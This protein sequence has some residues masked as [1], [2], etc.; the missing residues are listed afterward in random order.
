MNEDFYST[1]K[2][3][4]ES[5]WDLTEQH[6]VVGMLVENGLT[7]SNPPQN[8]APPEADSR[9][10]QS[11]FNLQSRGLTCDLV[12]V[13]SQDRT[14]YLGTCLSLL[15]AFKVNHPNLAAG[16]LTTGLSEKAL[17]HLVLNEDW[18]LLSGPFFRG[19]LLRHMPQVHQLTLEL[20]ERLAHH[21]TLG[22]VFHRNRTERYQRLSNDLDKIGAYKHWLSAINCKCVVTTNEQLDPAAHLICAAKELGI[23]TIRF[24]M[25]SRRVCTRP[26]Y[27]TSFGFGM[28]HNHK[29]FKT[30]GYV[31]NNYKFLVFWSLSIRFNKN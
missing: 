17:R 2:A 3:L 29:P 21:P 11:A 13:P 25:G 16:I 30:G 7:S 15:K 5:L 23:E 8:E 4:T 22:H 1:W 19:P 9:G 18:P 10:H 14:N 24:C 28:K 26:C 27:L 12:F 31:Q 20:E 6:P